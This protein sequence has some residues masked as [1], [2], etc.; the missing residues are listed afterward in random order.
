MTR[1]AAASSQPHRLWF[2][3]VLILALVLRLAWLLFAARPPQGLHDPSLYVIAGIE[4]AIGNGYSAPDGTPTAYFPVG[5]PALLGVVFHL[6][7]RFGPSRLPTAEEMAA[8]AR[9]APTDQFTPLLWD[10]A[11]AGAAL[12]LLLG[13]ATVAL[14]YR[15]G[16]QLFDRS[17]GLIAALWVA[18]FPSLVFHTALLLS[19]TLFCFLVMIVLALLLSTP[20]RGREI[21]PARLLTSGAALGL[22]ALVRPLSLLILPLLFLARLQ[23]GSG[24]RGALRCA[25]LTC[26][27]TLVVMGPWTVRNALVMPEPVLI[28]TNTGDN[29]C[30][31]HHPGARG[32][33]SATPYCLAD[34]PYAGIPR[35]EVEVRR[36]RDNIRKALRFASEN[37]HAELI[38]VGRKAFHLL[39]HDHD[40]LTVAE[41]WGMDAFIAPWLRRTLERVADVFFFTTLCLG[42]IGM[43]WIAW[44]PRDPR[45]LMLL[46]A[47]LALILAPLAFFG[48]PRFHV[49]V[50]PLL[51]VAAARVALSL[52][53]RMRRL[54]AD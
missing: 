47:F 35:V 13:V 51:A 5:Y 11:A 1:P 21:S 39:R 37:P 19:E 31:G 38:L 20:W 15:V 32:N 44:Q 42:L 49:P 46:Y 48:D 18:V 2:C 50:L 12:N 17:A 14:V 30:I 54:P 27:G 43:L 8:A 52:F 41:S 23:A 24:L 22:S 25:A 33:Y 9:G 6:V 36:N 7:G 34:E 40:A 28:S 53:R 4:V 29:L 26:V 10:L 3:A 45:R 16:R